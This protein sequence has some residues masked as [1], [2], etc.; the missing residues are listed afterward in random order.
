VL[1]IA[2]P[3]FFSRGEWQPTIGWVEQIRELR[4]VGLGERVGLPLYPYVNDR[5]YVA[6]SFWAQI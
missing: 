3:L 1:F 6:S 5:P 4:L 2:H